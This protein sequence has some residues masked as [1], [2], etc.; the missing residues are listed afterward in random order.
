MRIAPRLPN[1]H[2]KADIV[3]NLPATALNH[4]LPLGFVIVLIFALVAIPILSE[5]RVRSYERMLNEVVEPA[6]A[7]LTDLYLAHGMA[8]GALR[9]IMATDDPD[10]RSAYAEA[11]LEEQQSLGRLDAYVRL[12]NDRVQGEYVRLRTSIGDL[13]AGLTDVVASPAAAATPAPHTSSDTEEGALIAAARLDRELARTANEL[14]LQV[15][16]AKQNDVRIAAVLLMLAIIAAGVVGWAGRRMYFTAQA[17]EQARED[18]VRV[19]ESRAR[20]IRGFSHDV[21][22]PLGGA[23]GYAQLLEAGILGDLTEKQAHGLHRLRSALHAALELI[24]DLVDLARAEAG[25]IELNVQHFDMIELV[26]ELA[27]EYSAAANAKGVDLQVREPASAIHVTSDRPRVRQILSNLFSNAVKYTPGGGSVRVEVRSAPARRQPDPQRWA[28]VSVIDTG[29]GIPSDRQHL[30]FREFSRLDPEGS[31]GAGLGLAIS[32]GLAHALGGNITVR[33][34]P[35]HGSTF[36]LWLPEDEA[37]PESS[38]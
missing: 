17:A 24:D 4:W 14:R 21:K 19:N 28:I 32:Q 20:L 3:K 1:A 7:E 15:R 30:L 25:R 2:G 31:S 35:G 38:L 16:A 11:V 33:S 5:R 26:R 29:P 37:G 10:A 34:K 12:L 22:N 23:D 18:L 6:R 13:R 27:D 9:E 8:G 36:A